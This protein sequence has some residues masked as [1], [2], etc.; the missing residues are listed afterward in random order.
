M[1]AD[2]QEQLALPRLQWPEQPHWS[3]YWTWNF[4]IVRNFLRR[5][6][7]AFHVKFVLVVMAVYAVQQGIG[8]SA[9]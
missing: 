8:V 6:S 5:L 1:C 4:R 7:H 2:E 9:S 3:D